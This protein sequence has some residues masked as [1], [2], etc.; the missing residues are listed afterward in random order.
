MTEF[1][2]KENDEKLA[3][4]LELLKGGFWYDKILQQELKP[5]GIS[6][7][8]FNILR[9]LEHNKDRKFSL[10]EIQSRIMNQTANTTRLLQKLKN[11]G[12]VKSEYCE[13]NR[14]KLEITITP[15]GL[16]LLT[17]LREPFFNTIR[18]VKARMSEQEAETLTKIIRKLRSS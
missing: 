5:F 17:E 18:E 2:G 3:A 4:L 16:Q 11:K 14:R 10:K 6:H 7:E 12:L 8:Q 1:A 15:R 13:H 9:I